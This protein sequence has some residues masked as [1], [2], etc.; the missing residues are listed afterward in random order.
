M[1]VNILT[2]DHKY[3]LCNTEILQQSIQMQLC[4]AKKLFL[5][6]LIYFWNLHQ[7]LNILEKAIT[8][9]SFRTYVLQ[10]T[11]LDKCLK[12][13]IWGHGWTVN[14]LK[15]PKH[16]LSL[17]GSDFIVYSY[18]SD[19]NKNGKFIPWWYLKSEHCL[20]IYWQ[21]ITSTLFLIGRSYLRNK[22]LSKN[23]SKKKD[24]F[25]IFLLHF[26]NL[27]QI[28]NIL[29]KKMT[30]IVYVFPKLRTEKDVVRKMSKNPRSRAPFDSQHAKVCQ[31]LLES[32]RH[33]FYHIYSSL[34]EKHSLKMSLLVI[35]EIL[36]LFLNIMNADYKHS[37]CNRE[38]LQQSIQM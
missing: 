9:F 24:I 15:G 20:L 12:S 31:T 27:N 18:H 19:R 10:K 7:I 29:K 1:F 3:S 36:A 26:W 28:S 38:N 33:H 16:W 34:W 30:L 21:P 17:Y 14:M 5:I 8:L 6:L 32:A 13:V 11:W 2:A 23:L 25:L 37:L 35:S 4:S 22:K